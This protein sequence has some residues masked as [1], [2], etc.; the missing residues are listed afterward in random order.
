MKI[1]DKGWAVL[2]GDTHLSKWVEESGD[3]Q[4]HQQYDKRFREFGLAAGDT[5]VD[6]GA[7]IGDTTIPMA[8]VVGHEGR[9]YAFEPNPL[10]FAC[11]VY[12]TH[13]YPQV[14]CYPYALGSSVAEVVN[15]RLCPNIGASHIG[16]GGLGYMAVLTTLD[17]F[18][19]SGVRFIKIDVEG[20]EVNAL[21]GAE[22]TIRVSRPALM[23]ETAVHGDRYGVDQRQILYKW[24]E[25]RDY[26]VNP[27]FMSL[28]NAPQYDIIAQ[29][30]SLIDI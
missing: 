20:F 12:N 22:S 28:E 26:K 11:L 29:P 13:R 16:G 6:I 18:E 24:L 4:H 25:D 27:H 8:E 2:E 5:A 19:I 7:C 14:T 1:T 21:R 3:I 17:F 10:A 30:K 15:I 23:V 9:V